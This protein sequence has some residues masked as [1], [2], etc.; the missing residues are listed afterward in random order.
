MTA[1]LEDLT[2]HNPGLLG[3]PLAGRE[4]GRGKDAY[5]YEFGPELVYRRAPFSI[6]SGFEESL[7]IAHVQEHA[8]REIEAYATL[9]PNTSVARTLVAWVAG[10]CVHKIIERA[11]GAPLH[12]RSEGRVAIHDLKGEWEAR[13][14]KVA[15]IP[16][17]HFDTLVWSDTELRNRTI[18]MDYLGIDNL[19]YDDTSGFTII[20]AEYSPQLPLK[21]AGM[22]V[23]LID[24]ESLDTLIP[25][26][27]NWEGRISSTSRDHVVTILEKLA[28]AGHKPGKSKYAPRFM[29]LCQQLAYS[30]DY[31][32][33][34][35]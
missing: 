26:E 14:E 11:E 15:Q 2:A 31:L 28:C 33:D 30:P 4:L 22:Y 23:S 12:N 5:A 9:P 6:P 10:N 18:F 25:R 35:K 27:S 24:T 21:G 1:G 13:V 17:A 8:R 3:Y 20:D 16:Q 29:K 34:Q 19:F 7:A 32:T